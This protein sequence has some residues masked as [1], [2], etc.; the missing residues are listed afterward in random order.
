M[1]E[2][3]MEIFTKTTQPLILVS[4]SA[5]LGL[6][7]NDDLARWQA[8]VKVPYPYLGDQSITHRKD[9][10]P[11][12][13]DWQTAKDLI[14]T[15]GRIVRSENDWGSTYILDDAFTG[16]YSRNSDLFPPFIREAIWQKP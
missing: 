14:Q 13:Y 2:Q 3:A 9:T 4:P 8:I 6:S 16:F 11:G 15:F 1:R 10:I 5:M 12:W 7:L